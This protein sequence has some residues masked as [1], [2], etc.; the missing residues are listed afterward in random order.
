MK[1]KERKM[2]REFIS[3]IKIQQLTNKPF[4]SLPKINDPAGPVV[5]IFNSLF[6]PCFILD[7]N[8]FVLQTLL[9][10]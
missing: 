7:H 6:H 5:F 2:F 3:K 10:P 1:R 4:K 9:I 8:G